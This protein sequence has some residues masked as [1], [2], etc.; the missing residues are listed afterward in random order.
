MEMTAMS[1]HCAVTIII[2]KCKKQFMEMTAMSTHYA[3]S[4]VFIFII[5]IIS[6]Y[7]LNLTVS[8][9]P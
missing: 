1:T 5:I 3:V 7:L 6:Y 4:F 2:Y 9:T 8:P